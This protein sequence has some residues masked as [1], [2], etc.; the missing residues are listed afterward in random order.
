VGYVPDTAKDAPDG[1]LVEA[2]KVNVYKDKNGN[3]VKDFEFVNG[4]LEKAIADDVGEIRERY[5]LFDYFKHLSLKDTIY[6]VN[7]AIQQI[8]DG[9]DDLLD[10]MET[11]E[12]FRLYKKHFEI[13]ENN[14]SEKFNS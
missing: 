12:K 6:D 11:K 5:Y 7:H 9:K 1:N 14:S 8:R 10:D 3:D 2:N 13:A 4:K